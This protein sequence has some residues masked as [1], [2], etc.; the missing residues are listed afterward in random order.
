MEIID[1]HVHFRDEE[2][3]YKYTINQGLK[4]AEELGIKIVGDM[5]NLPRP[6]INEKRVLERLK[7]VPK[8]YKENYKLW[9]GLTSNHNQIVEAIECVD[10]YYEVVGLKLFAGKSIGELAVSEYKNQ[11]KVFETL[12][13]VGYK[14]LIAVHCEKE[15]FIRNY[16]NPKNPI[17]HLYSRPEIAEIESVKDIINIAKTVKFKGIVYFCHI[18]SPRAFEIIINSNINAIIEITPHHI[19][20]TAEKYKKYPEGLLFKVNPPLRK[21]SS[22]IKLRHLIKRHYDKVVYGSDHAPHT[23]CEKLYFPYLSGIPSMIY[24]H[25]LIKKINIS[26]IF[27]ENQY[28]LL[29][30]LNK[31]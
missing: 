25:E 8:K 5:P 18:S 6:V 14:G 11:L 15:E 10:K 4:L 19:L 24:V 28:K 29:K 17:T 27:Y 22:V 21:K 3:K 20:W 30:K 12:T 26:K 16:F 13:E 31:I 1:L 23:I 7:L 2:W 9:V